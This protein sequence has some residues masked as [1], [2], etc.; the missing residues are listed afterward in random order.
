M[1]ILNR[2]TQLTLDALWKEY[3]LES[4]EKARMTTLVS[5]TVTNF[6]NE[7]IKFLQMEEGDLYPSPPPRDLPMPP[8]IWL[9]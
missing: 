7:E 2:S 6:E 3:V 4:Q 9:V 1:E 5:P 8:P